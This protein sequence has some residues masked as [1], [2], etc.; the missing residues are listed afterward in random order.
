MNFS[1]NFFIP[2]FKLAKV[3]KIDKEATCHR[4]ENTDFW[5][6][7]AS[8]QELNKGKNNGIFLENTCD[9]HIT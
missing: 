4:N 8:M 9:I 1:T 6:S 3:K 7:L 5:A 2:F